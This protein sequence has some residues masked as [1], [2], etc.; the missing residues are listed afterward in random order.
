MG[1]KLFTLF[2]FLL[3]ALQLAAQANWPFDFSRGT[4][5]LHIDPEKEKIEGKVK[6]KFTSDKTVDSVYLDARNMVLEEVRFN[7]KPSFFKYDGRKLVVP[8]AI[9]PGKTYRMEIAYRVEPKQ[10]VYFLGWKDSIS[11]N[12]Q[13]WTQGQG[14]YTSHWVPSPDIMSEKIIFDMRITFDPAYEVIANGKLRKIKTRKGKKTWHYQMVKPMSSYLLAFAIGKYT[15]T[16]LSSRS[17]IPIRLYMY[18]EALQKSEPTYRY[19]KRIFDFLEAE[20]GIPY[21]WQNYRQV[22]VRDF[23]YAGM[24]NTGITI[25][26]DGY[27]IDSTAFRDLNYVNVNAHELAHQWFGNLVTETD[28]AQHWLHE[29][30]ATYYAYLSE[31]ELFGDDYFYWKLWDTSQQLRKQDAQGSG[32]A[33]TDPKAGSL[34]FYEKG[35]WVAL[36]LNEV[37]GKDAF[38]NGIRE[39]LSRYAFKN[40]T[41]SQF[42]E[43]MEEQCACNLDKFRSIWIDSSAYPYQRCLDY[44]NS[45]SNSIRL[46]GEIQKELT[47]S[48]DSNEF[49]VK[50]YW[51]NIN[52]PELKK[53][54]ILRYGNSLSEEYLA[55]ISAEGL[56]EVRQAVA[57]SLLKASQKTRAT[58]ESLLNDISYITKENA[59]YKLWL[60]YPDKREQYLETTREIIGLPNKSFRLTWLLLA[61]LTPNYGQPATRAKWQ[62]ELRGYTAGHYSFEVRQNAFVILHDVLGLNDSNLK[63]LGQACVHHVW[64]FR[65][66]ARNLMEE[67]IENEDYRIRIRA[68][69]DQLGPE[70]QDYLNTIL[71]V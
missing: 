43:V 55:A 57:V 52:D 50:K 61:S 51:G 65:N 18:P 29:G 6:Y 1:K 25:F 56:P 58:L 31:R 3:F 66:F 11:G 22:P 41:I 23:L 30:L 68:L 67:L 15:Y 26:S 33:L 4:I 48:P 47:V 12:N 42:L 70:E 7:G 16:D 63:D 19:S 40:A 20:I 49:I 69:L 38:R 45:H 13:I 53:R 71:G 9:R 14:K 59:L 5:T 44:L 8:K 2:F 64:Q 17:N 54:I 46:F 21:P 35:A 28:A 10:A 24:E 36:M 32:E 37:L 34:T 39:F 62:A 60:S 27:V